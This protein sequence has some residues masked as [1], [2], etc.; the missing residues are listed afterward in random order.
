MQRLVIANSL[1]KNLNC[2]CDIQIRFIV[3]SSDIM[4]V[5]EWGQNCFHI[6]NIV[7][8]ETALCKVKEEVPDLH[9]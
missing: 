2:Y 7:V 1:D 6:L 5:Y 9:L 8:F 4:Y 3:D